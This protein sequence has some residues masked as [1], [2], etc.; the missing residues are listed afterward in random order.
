M[1]SYRPSNL[2]RFAVWTHHGAKC[3]WCHKPLRLFLEMEIEHVIPQHLENKS[4]ELDR[5]REDYGLSPDFVINDYC[6]WLPCHSY[7]NKSKGGKLPDLTPQITNTLAG[8]ARDAETIRSIEQRAKSNIDLD[9]LFARVVI[10][11]ETGKFTRDEILALFPDPELTHDEGIQILREEVYLDVD[12]HYVDFLNRKPDPNGL[13]FWTN[14]IAEGHQASA[15]SRSDVLVNA[16]AAF[17][18]STEFYEIGYLVYRMYT[19]AY[20]RT[21]GVSTQDRTHMLS[22]PIVRLSEFVPAIQQIGQGVIEGKGDWQ[23]QLETNKAAFVLD[24]VSRSRFTLAYPTSL[25]PTQF[26]D[27][28]CMNA[29]GPLSAAG[30]VSVINEFGEATSS[31]DTAARARSLRR[32]AENQTFVQQE[33]NKAFVLMLYFGYLRRDPDDTPDRDFT[34]YDFWLRKL[35]EFNGDY[36]AAEL[37]KAFLTSDEYKRRFGSVPDSS[38]G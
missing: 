35:N 26:V 12:Q 14:Q 20:G 3:Y 19:A 2:Q 15:A 28:L 10:A 24:F 22:V 29:G 27:A 8:L 23:N 6:N 37:F 30:R 38:A 7:C 18:L 36:V 9:K 5:V 11:H 32:V 31:V 17:F 16:S 34:G 33:F 4:A 21:T 1:G 13:A 25:T